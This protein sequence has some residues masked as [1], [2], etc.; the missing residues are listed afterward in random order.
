MFFGNASGLRPIALAFAISILFA[1][2]MA[3]AQDKVIK[4]GAPLALTGGLAEEGHKQQEAYKLWLG[5][6]NEAHADGRHP[7]NHAHALRGE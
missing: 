5:K 1:S 4:I 7:R 3:L 2:G 6:V